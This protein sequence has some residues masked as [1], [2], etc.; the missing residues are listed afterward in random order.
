V[1][2]LTAIQCVISIKKI[3]GVDFGYHSIIGVIVVAIVPIA[4]LS[5][6][7]TVLAGKPFIKTREWKTH[8]E[9]KISTIGRFHRKFGYFSLFC[10]IMGTSSGIVSWQEHFNDGKD[11]W[12]A[13]FCIVG[14]LVV[15]IGSE[16]VFRRWRRN[17]RREL[18]PK[19]KKPEM[20]V[21]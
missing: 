6:S 21:E 11:K 14:S 9:E 4:T 16:V 3:G 7:A 8:H 1:F 19:P 17:H 18:T 20:T 13:D 2:W 15:I 5:G 12:L 10:G